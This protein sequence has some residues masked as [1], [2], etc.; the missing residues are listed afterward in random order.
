[1]TTRPAP[2]IQ[3]PPIMVDR[4][5]AA[6]ALGIGERTLESLVAEGRLPPPRKISAQR[7]GWLWTELVAAAQALPVSDHQPG[8]GRRSPRGEP[9]AG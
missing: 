6:T 8:P 2:I 3:T 5:Q 1:M 9:I 7:V 4:A